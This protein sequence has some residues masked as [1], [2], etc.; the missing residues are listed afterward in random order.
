M[1]ALLIF[2]GWVAILLLEGWVVASLLFQRSRAAL[3]AAALPF[4]AL[5]NVFLFFLWTIA[6]LPLRWTT[7]LP[8]H[9]LVIAAL[10]LVRHFWM[11][12]S[13]TLI[14]PVP[15]FPT[16]S[17]RWDQI[18]RIACLLLLGMT[19]LFSL[20]HAVLLPTFQIDSLTNWTMR[21]KLSFLDEHIA[22][23]TDEV[24]GMS[25]PQYP[26]LFHALQILV[27]EGNTV[28]HDQSANGILFLLNIGSLVSLFFVVRG[29]RGTTQALV[30]VTLLTGI[31]L[32][33]FHL[34]GSYA[35][36]HLALFLL[37]ALGWFCTALARRE[38]SSL[39]ASALLVAAATWT[40]SE[41]IVIGLLPWTLLLLLCW[42]QFGRLRVL[43]ALGIAWM[44]SVP[45]PLFLLMRGLSLTPHAT[46]TRF[47]WHPEGVLPALQGLFSGGSFGIVWYA[48]PAIIVLLFSAHRRRS[49]QVDSLL[50]LTLLWGIVAFLLVLATYLLTPNISFLLSG[51]SFYRQ[52]MIPPALMLLSCAYAWRRS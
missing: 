35:D 32:L 21:S 37:L 31:P 8:A 20:V 9:L 50:L 16:S 44:C 52:M 11:Q 6:G 34:A 36:M 17:I 13:D 29:L 49:P 39:F 2:S 19:A 42:K 12:K 22:F 46:D 28:W 51:Q 1:T 7:L 23:D 10:L 40:K 15:E 4:A 26:F 5:S 47:G 27:N 43:Q 30:T 38:R 45:W 18:L 33:G 24:R 25:K 14:P 41:G 48:L 3:L